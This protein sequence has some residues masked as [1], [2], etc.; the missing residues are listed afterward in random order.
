MAAAPSSDAAKDWAPRAPAP[1]AA[2][3]LAAR[4]LNAVLGPQP[5]GMEGALPPSLRVP[6]REAGNTPVDDMRG[7]EPPD[8]SDERLVARRGEGAEP[9]PLPRV[10]LAIGSLLLVA[11]TVALGAG[12]ASSE[13]TLIAMG[14]IAFL[15]GA[16]STYVFFLVYVLRRRDRFR[17]LAETY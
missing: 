17:E 16:Y 10:R 12:L 4:T 3:S 11:G 13:T 14:A 5:A 7:A 2:P 9:P 1:A 8:L 15:P 6:H